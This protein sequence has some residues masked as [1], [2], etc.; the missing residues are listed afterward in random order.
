MSTIVTA[1]ESVAPSRLATV[2]A[3]AIYLALLA[4]VWFVAQEQGVAVRLGGH[5]TAGFFAFAGLFLPYWA[6]GW[7]CAAPVRRWLTAP[8]ARVVAPSVLVLPYVGFAA[9]THTFQVHIFVILLA[10]PVGLAALFQF[11]VPEDAAARLLWADLIA[12]PVLGLPIMLNWLGGAFP[13]PGLGS[14]FVKLLL[15]DSALYAY[16]VVR[17]L[18][19]IGY[20]FRLQARDWLIGLREWAWFA[21]IA[22]GLG[23]ALAFIRFNPRWHDVGLAAGAW[24]GIFLFVA[25]PEELFFRGLVQNLFET[26]WGRNWA[27]A[28]AAVLFGA[29]HFHHPP[30][31]NWRYMLLAALAGIFYGRAWRD[32]RRVS[33]SAI[34][35]ATVDM[36]WGLWFR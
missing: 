18:P 23:L 11:G 1:S 4:A 16:L 7:G 25:V 29:A 36:V 5:L 15:I 27:L 33:C 24:L 17:H 31:P 34:T 21:P 30:V 6:F 19:G 9:A 26:R 3:V 20:D 35:H 28:G 12:L 8:A 32:R 22:I 2:L 10:I 14:N 13:Y